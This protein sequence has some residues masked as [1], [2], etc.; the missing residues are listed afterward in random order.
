MACSQCQEKINQLERNASEYR[1]LA[2]GEFA[3]ARDSELAGY[4]GRDHEQY[5]S[6]G[7]YFSDKAS[8]CMAEA[9][10]IRQACEGR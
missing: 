10:R 2:S 5:F 3:K 7:K 8:E 6:K 1:E 9:Y 4:K